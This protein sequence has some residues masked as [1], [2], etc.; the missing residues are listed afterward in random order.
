MYC[1]FTLADIKY[2]YL[3]VIHAPTSAR[4][5]VT[6]EERM[7]TNASAGMANVMSWT[8]VLDIPKCMPSRSKQMATLEPELV[9]ARPQSKHVAG[10]C[11]HSQH[12]G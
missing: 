2:R 3:G 5:Q 1:V 7:G 11:R 4:F 10:V 9:Y 8:T 12:R 6:H